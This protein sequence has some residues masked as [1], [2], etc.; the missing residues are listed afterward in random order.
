[1]RSR[2]AARTRPCG[3]V[4]ERA[5]AAGGAEASRGN[6]SDRH[7]ESTGA[8]FQE[9][10][11]RPT[12]R[13]PIDRVITVQRQKHRA[14]SRRVSHGLE[15]H[16]GCGRHRA[17]PSGALQVSHLVPREWK[18]SARYVLPAG[19]QESARKGTFLHRQLLGSAQ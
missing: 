4:A 1:V 7:G 5:A 12:E 15:S 3:G 13:A 10:V 17:R 9:C 2:E 14:H 8:E 18:R 16:G 19:V 6:L 11:P